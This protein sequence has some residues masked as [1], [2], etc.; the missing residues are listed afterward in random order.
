MQ[1]MSPEEM[2]RADRIAIDE[3][4]V[5]GIDLMERAG[6]GV[7]REIARRVEV[8][9][10]EL[11]ILCGKG[12]NGGDGFVAARHLVE[13]GAVVE[14]MLFA[15]ERDLRGDA[16]AMFGRL[17]GTGVVVS[18]LSGGEGDGAAAERI[19]RAIVVVDALLGTGF[20]GKPRGRVAD[21]IGLAGGAKGMVAA[22]DAPSGVNTLSGRVEGAAVRADLTATLCASKHGLH[23]YPGA[24]FAGEVVVVPI[25]IPAEAVR[26]AAGKTSLFAPG[27][28]AI[29]RRRRDAHKGEFGR[30]VI[31]GGALAYA[32]AP[33]LAGHAALRSGAGLVTLALPHSVHPLVAGRVPELM[34]LPLETGGDLHGT[35]GAAELLDSG[36]KIDVIAAGP[37]LARGEHPAAFMKALLARWDGSLVID[38]DG[39]H[40]LVGE[41]EAIRRSDAKIVLTPHLGEMIALTGASKEEILGDPIGFVRQQAA[42]LGAVLLLKGNPTIVADREG[43]VTLNTTGNPGMATA[44]SGDVLTGVIGA[45]LGAGFEPAEATRLAVWLHGRAGDLAAEALGEEGVIARDVIEMLPRAIREVK[46]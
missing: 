23:L 38:A 24:A 42:D 40:A 30:I 26:K 3:M 19:A 5:P 15:R 21:A 33:I 17:A 4:G 11:I 37:G 45:M 20:S 46:S 2:R 9:G 6:A 7:A 27:P 43:A 10:K 36:M 41:K 14:V 44:G 12:N 34:C 25:G 22:V 8:A 35:K 1:L 39:I 16:A 31:A 13:G 18:D 28:G 32:G 29:P